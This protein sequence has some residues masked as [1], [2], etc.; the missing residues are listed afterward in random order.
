ML[1][2]LKKHLMPLQRQ[3]QIIVWSD[4]NLNAGAEWEKE[5][6]QHL[7][8][9]DII[10]LLI[11]PYFMN[12]EY[13]YSKEMKRAIERHDQGHSK[14]IPLLLRSVFW[15]NAP[16]AKI[17]MLPTDAKPI[18]NWPDRDDAYHDIVRHVHRVVTELQIRR[19]QIAEDKHAL[20]EQQRVVKQPVVLPD[21]SAA[22]PALSFAP[23]VFDPTKLTLLQ[24]LKGHTRSVSSI[25]ISPDGKILV[26][27]SIDKTIRLWELPS[28]RELSTLIGH[29]G[30][31]VSIAISP[32]G[33]NLVSG[34]HDGTIRLWELP[35]GRELHTLPPNE[36]IVSDVAISPDGKILVGQISS[37]IRLWEL[38]SGRELHTLPSD[39]NSIVHIAISPDGT[40]LA[41]GG[42][43]SHRYDV[44]AISLWEL[45]SGRKL[46]TLT[47]N[48]N[49]SVDTAV[50]RVAFSPDGKILAIPFHQTQ[51]GAISLWE[52]PSGHQLYRLA[53]HTLSVSSV[54]FSPDGKILASGGSYDKTIKLWEVSSGRELHKLTGHT[55]TISSMAFTS[56]GSILASGSEDGDMTIKLWGMES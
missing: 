40:I 13:C 51:T 44:N 55:G 38:P 43:D 27:G 4:T 30:S 24:T 8:N 9:A 39:I 22:A 25:A 11:S 18:T 14:V 33:K 23:T 46:S 28:G 26:S 17:Q 20:A 15:D 56:D 34:S 52:L 29:T 31:V 16:F 6:H 36:Y 21:L 42:N 54:T 2:H 48:T 35:S 12:S 3:G 41:S 1:E 10:L 32:D 47:M 49:H 5:L 50:T 45:P 37:T 7:E 53:G 19:T